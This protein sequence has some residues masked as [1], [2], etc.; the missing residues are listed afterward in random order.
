M[1]SQTFLNLPK[2]KQKT[3]LYAA[4]KEFTNVSYED[5]SINRIIKEAGIPRGSFY[6]YFENKEDL[7]LYLLNN[8]KIRFQEKLLTLISL[9]HGDIF[10]TFTKLYDTMIDFCM[11][12]AKIAFF[13]QVFTNIN[14]KTENHLFPKGEKPERVKQSELYQNFVANIDRTILVD[15]SDSGVEEILELLF[16]MTIHTTIHSFVRGISKEEAKEIYKRKIE[17]LKYGMKKK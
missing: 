3:L 8:Y 12:P 5:V 2:E 1:P 6:M 15:T 7:Y 17:L 4:I 9:E 11:S 16:M 10:E 13:R 14:S